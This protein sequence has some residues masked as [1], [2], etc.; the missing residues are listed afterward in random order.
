MNLG[1][2]GRKALV[3]AS[4]QGLGRACAQALASE[5]A[6]VTLNGRDLQRLEHAQ[7][8]IEEATGRRP[9][10]IVADINTAEGR[11]TLGAALAQS[12]ILVTNNAGPTPGRFED[13]DE[14]AWTNALNASLMAPL[15]IVRAALPGMRERRF[16]RIVNITSA[17]VKAPRAAM[18]L[19]TTARSGLTAMC[20]A[21]S[22]EVVRDNVTINNLLPER[23][24]TERLL[25]MTQWTAQQK[26]LSFEAARAEMLRPVPA[27]RFGTPAEFGAACAFL[28]SSL[29]GYITGQNLQIDGGSYP[30]VI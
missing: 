18:G 21:L 17:M 24:D 9:A 8:V 30:G 14:V 1:I 19:S 5:G 27:G 6:A 10:A 29:A 15:M 28:C 26:G 20:K 25:R 7:N 11:A 23:I 22:V 12:D 16:G 13:W 3:C 2:A 4:S